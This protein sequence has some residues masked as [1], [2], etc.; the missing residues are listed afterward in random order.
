LK[1]SI[2]DLNGPIRATR[3]LREKSGHQRLNP[4]DG[5]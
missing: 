5:L 1:K 3:Q 4:E 2:E